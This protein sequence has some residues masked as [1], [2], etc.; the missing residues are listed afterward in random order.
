MMELNISNLRASMTDG[1]LGAALRAAR[2]DEMPDYLTQ[3]N[4]RM[5]RK[6]CGHLGYHSSG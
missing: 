5:T 1:H 3:L 6:L 4:M 2:T